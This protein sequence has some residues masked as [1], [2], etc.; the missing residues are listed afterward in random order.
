LARSDQGGL[1]V[2]PHQL[3]EKPASFAL[4]TTENVKLPA[5]SRSM[6][7]EP[8]IRLDVDQDGGSQQRQTRFPDLVICNSREVIG[9]VEIKYQPRVQPNWQK[10]LRTF[11]WIVS[12]RDRIAISNEHFLGIGVDERIYPLAKDVLF[13][14]VGVHRTWS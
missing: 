8:S 13:A 5:K 10:D 6:F 2:A 3:G 12:N 11:L 9:I 4:V 7:I 1:S 14:W